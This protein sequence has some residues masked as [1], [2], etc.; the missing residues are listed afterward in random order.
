VRL[1]ENET[2]QTGTTIQALS[3]KLSGSHGKPGHRRA[4]PSQAVLSIISLFG[5]YLVLKGAPVAAVVWT[6]R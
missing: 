5:A 4:V 6:L 3:D 1:A 2:R